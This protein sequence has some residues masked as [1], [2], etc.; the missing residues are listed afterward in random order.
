EALVQ[1]AL[2]RLMQ[3]C[4]VLVIAHRLSTVEN[5]HRIVVLEKGEIIEIGSHSQ[6]LAQGGRYAQFHARQFSDIS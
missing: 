2:Q 5:A 3:Q 4:T 6:L 1:E